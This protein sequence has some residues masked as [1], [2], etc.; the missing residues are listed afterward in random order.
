MIRPIGN[1]RD[2]VSIIAPLKSVCIVK[3]A[4]TK[5]EIKLIPAAKLNT[6]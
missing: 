1:I 3:I 2:K 4:I 5:T 6:E